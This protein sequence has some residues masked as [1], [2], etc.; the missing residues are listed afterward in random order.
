MILE[1]IDEKLKLLKQG[2]LREFCFAFEIPKNLTSDEYDDMLWELSGFGFEDVADMLPA[3]MV[4]DIDNY[5]GRRIRPL[6]DALVCY[7][8]N[9][10]KER[11]E[12]L[13]QFSIAQLRVI[14]EWQCIFSRLQWGEGSPELEPE[15]EEIVRRDAHVLKAIIREKVREQTNGMST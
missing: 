10:D 1:N 13:R 9:N 11:V 14:I 15:F 7:L 4:Q 5:T 6:T 12:L 8:S 3:M 2:I